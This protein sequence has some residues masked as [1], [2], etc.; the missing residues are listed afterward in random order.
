MRPEPNSSFSFFLIWAR[1]Q[2]FWFLNETVAFV[3]TTL[4]FPTTL[5]SCPTTIIVTNNATS[6]PS[7]FAKTARYL[8]FGHFVIKLTLHRHLEGLEDLY[9]SQCVDSAEFCGNLHIP[10]DSDKHSRCRSIH[11]PLDRKCHTLN[12]LSQEVGLLSKFYN[13]SFC[14]RINCLDCPIRCQIEAR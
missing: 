7:L 8:N 9:S 2:F 11:R 3:L 12:I 5:T 13:R 6:K 4:R 14:D 1:A 10:D